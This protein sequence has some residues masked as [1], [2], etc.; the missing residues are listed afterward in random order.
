MQRPGRRAVGPIAADRADAAAKQVR[1]NCYYACPHPAAE[2]VAEK[3]K[4]GGCRYRAVEAEPVATGFSGQQ[5][6]EQKA[7][8]AAVRR[9]GVQAVE[10][11]SIGQAATF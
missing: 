6:L 8:A 3:Y 1:P 7:K 2:P 4:L 11:C 10:V 9:A 5:E